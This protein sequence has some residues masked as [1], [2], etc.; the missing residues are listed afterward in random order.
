[1]SILALLLCAFLPQEK[2]AEVLRIEALP[3]Q[4]FHSPYLLHIPAKVRRQRDKT[5]TL[6]VLPNNTGRPSDDLA[7][8]AAEARRWL[9][10]H[11]LDAEE[12][13]LVLLVPIF[14][15]PQKDWRIYTHALDRDTMLT[16]K[17]PLRRPDL[18]LLAMIDH[19][20]GEQAKAGVKL[21]RKVFLFGFSACGMFVNRFVF[22]HPD[23]VKAAALGS[24][25]GWP[26]VP[27]ADYQ[28]KP[29]RYPI[30]TADWEAIT[31][32][33]LDLEKLA[34]VP[35][36][37]FLGAKDTNDSVIY[38]DSYDKED[39]DLIL[40]HFGKT[41]QERWKIAETLYH[42]K[43]P[44]ATFKLYPNVGHQITAEMRQE[45]MTFFRKHLPP[46]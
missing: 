28:G 44:I 17:P 4:G 30:G 27:A 10:R 37:L 21:D 32:T 31:G 6:L 7:V 45:V 5:H 42:L 12:L 34:Q 2:P 19:A 35:L 20:I 39:E 38:R 11:R 8:H 9:D 23:R 33:K 16:Q 25:G 15:R 43:L 36:F 1:M 40:A 18:Q 24:P 41:L 22:L 29:L 3:E 13:G 46:N 26:L 14:P